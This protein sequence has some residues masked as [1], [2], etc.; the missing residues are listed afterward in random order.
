MS[1]TNSVD[2]AMQVEEEEE[3]VI[4]VQQGSYSLGETH[5]LIR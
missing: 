2:L 3:E 4:D 5:S 1:S